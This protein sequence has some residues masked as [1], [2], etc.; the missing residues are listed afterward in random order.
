VWYQVLYGMVTFVMEVEEVE[1]GD[2]RPVEDV[3]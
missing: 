1:D 2:W 3:R